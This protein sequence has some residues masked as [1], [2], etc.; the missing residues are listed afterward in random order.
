MK[1]GN[2][3]FLETSGP[4]QACN[5]TALPLPFYSFLLGGCVN[6]RG[7]NA[8][9]RIMSMKNSSDTFGNRTRDLPVCSAFP[10]PNALPRAPRFY[11]HIKIKM[12][13][14][15][16]PFLLTQIFEKSR[17]C[18]S[19]RCKKICGH[20]AFWRWGEAPS[21]YPCSRR[22]YVSSELW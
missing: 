1:S 22:Q 13:F 7:H 18:F 12:R 15:K 2:L 20:G 8:A 4:L 21:L 14:S 6:P 19:R 5:G 17:K 16:L 9:G 10:Q 3:T 11:S